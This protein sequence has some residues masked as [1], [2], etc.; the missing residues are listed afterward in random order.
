MGKNDT[1]NTKMIRGLGLKETITITVGTVVGVGLFTVGANG[2]GYLGPSIIWAT[3]A[4]F[5]FSIYPALL[6]AEM[7]SMLPFAG[8]TY[9]YAKIGVGKPWG[10]LAGW[11]FVISLISVVSGEALAFS[12]YFK[13]M[14]EGMGITLPIDE[15]IIASLI[16][17]VFIV[18]NYRG[19]EIAG[20]WQNIFMFFFWGVSLIWF[21]LMI[22]H[23]NLHSYTPFVGSG[24][25]GLRE[26][27]FVTSLVWWCF[28]GFET[29]CAMGEEI[30]YPQINIPRAMFL[31]PFIIF[32]VNAI[33]QWFLLG[34]VPPSG[35]GI[36]KDSAAP[37]AEA[38]KTAGIMGIPLVILCAAIAFGGDL[39]TLNAG[40][41]APA[42]YLYSM[43]R[44][45]AL[46]PVFSKLHPK[47][48]TPYVAVL[49]LGVITLL[50]V[51]T[52]SI[53]YIASL[54]LFAD[55]FYYIIG[56]MGAIGLRMK[57]PELKRPYRAPML[58]VGAVISIL[59]YLV[60]TTQLDREAV[61]TGI[62]WSVVGLFL[63]YIWTRAKSD[64][65]MPL[66]LPNAMQELPEHP[67]AKELERLN[68]EYFIW[69]NI[70]GI[71]FILSISLYFLPH[72]F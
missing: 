66:D 5:I 11:N 17:I 43:S 58:K 13:W 20:K 71:A 60:M 38:M 67:P 34:I 18:I 23:I 21:F 2:V 37:Y 28:A 48:K 54:S 3:F 39:S 27:I 32:I 55:L 42:R 30:Q 47:Y 35:L 31:S 61:I 63:Y 46:P 36:I 69:R 9:N 25:T 64:E 12:N 19:V 24:N 33:F 40:V 51:S 65:E 70:V 22:P 49:F 26:F 45:A 16:I 29:A 52:G 6:Y 8:G 59:A 44:D 7:G 14:F 50:F 68:R 53:I 72:I 57:W 1:V 41:A 4:A 15:R 10:F 62:L 56:F